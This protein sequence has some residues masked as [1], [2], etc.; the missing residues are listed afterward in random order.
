MNGKNITM[1][2]TKKDINK[3]VNILFEGWINIAH[4]YAIVNCFQLI[5]LWKNY[6]E[7]INFYVHE[8]EYYREEWNSKKQLVYTDEYNKILTNTEYLIPF[9]PEI[10]KDIK[11]DLIY[12][13]TY[14]YD[15]TIMEWNRDIPI[16]VF[17]T[18]EFSKL[19]QNYFKI[20]APP[21]TNIDSDYIKMYLNYFKNVSFTSPSNWSC[22][23]MKEFINNDASRDPI[24]SHGVDP[25]L[26]YKESDELRQTVRK[27]YNVKPNEI[28]LI[29]IGAM[30]KNKGILY[31]LQIM[32]ILVNRLNKKHFKLLLKGT[33]DL[34]Q[35]KQFLESYFEE[36]QSGNVVTKEEMNILLNN[37]I[38]FTEKTLSFKQIRYLYNA[39]DMYISPY[40]AEGF[41]LCC[42]EA[43]ACGLKVLVPKTGSTEKYIN[44]IYNN[45]GKDSIYYVN[46]EIITI[47][48][49]LK[50]NNIDGNHLL[51]VMINFENDVLKNKKNENEKQMFEYIK[52]NYSWDTISTQLY[53]HF[54][55]LIK[56]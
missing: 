25:S 50:T 34:Y 39:C 10:D 19:D 13:I 53:N 24:I 29:N 6:N 49:E 30:T 11:I 37:H 40:I 32:N 8:K 17:Y 31:I 23:G 38:I 5:H 52:A 43:L 22:E 45:G 9:N 33:S 18:S 46:S 15:I 16:C 28:L 4:S 55:T 26:F 20:A 3:K 44:D 2:I 56:N 7:H 47:N 48:G 36:L 12:R 1:N 14:P 51:S 41:N 21:N 54:M 35:T 42:L 27:R